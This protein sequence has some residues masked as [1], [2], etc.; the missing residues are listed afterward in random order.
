MKEFW[1]TVYN[2]SESK[3]KKLVAD[4]KTRTIHSTI[5]PKKSLIFGNATDEEIDAIVDDIVK[6]GYDYGV[7]RRG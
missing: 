7:T 4:H 1:I 6:L 3:V 2:V 5:L